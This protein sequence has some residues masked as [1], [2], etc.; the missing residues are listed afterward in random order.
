MNNRQEHFNGLSSVQNEGITD[1]KLTERQVQTL[2]FGAHTLRALDNLRFGPSIENIQRAFNMLRFLDRKKSIEMFNKDT[3][4]GEYTFVP[5]DVVTLIDGIRDYQQAFELV[6]GLNEF[7]TRGI[8]K[9]GLTRTQVLTPR[10]SESMLTVMGVLQRGNPDADG[11]YLYDTAIHMLEEYQF[12]GIIENQL[13]LEQVG[14][15]VVDG[16]FIQRSSNPWFSACHIDAT[17]HLMEIENMDREQAYQVAL[18]LNSTQ[19]SGMINF[20]LRLDQVQHPF[21]S[22]DQ[23][24]LAELIEQLIQEDGFEQEDLSIPLD[25]EQQ[26]KVRNIFDA[27]T[28]L[29][30]IKNTK[31]QMLNLLEEITEFASI[32]LPDNQQNKEEEEISA[33]NLW[34]GEITQYLQLEGTDFFNMDNGD[35]SLEERKVAAEDQK[36]SKNQFVG[37]DVTEQHQNTDGVL[38]RGPSRGSRERYYA[39]RDP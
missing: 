36:R 15:I 11:P 18:S 1:Y 26:E 29:A 21:F 4:F 10:F 31:N 3:N 16:T 33:R 39:K 12:R 38:E 8:T 5:N 37:Q 22:N 25:Q 28:S 2:N 30:A 35:E 14:I 19:I 23:L 7:R 13:T 17:A 27:R 34:G 32:P 9:H 24:V 6:S 20:G